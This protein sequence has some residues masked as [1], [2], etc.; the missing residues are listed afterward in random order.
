LT[1]RRD[2]WRFQV[3]EL[4]AAT[5]KGG[6]DGNRDG[7]A[8]AAGSEGATVAVKPQEKVLRSNPVLEAFGNARTVR[9]DNSSRFGKFIELQFDVTALAQVSGNLAA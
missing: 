2:L 3:G 7:K 8:A 6:T 5:A 1:A 9:N 4:E